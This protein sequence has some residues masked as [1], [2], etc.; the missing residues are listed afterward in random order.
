MNKSFYKN[1]GLSIK[2]WR[3]IRKMTQQ[4]LADKIGKGINFTGKIEVAFSKPRLDTL[5]DIADALD[6]TVSQLTDFK[7]LK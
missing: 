7:A 2:K 1:L 6:I 4:Q 5:I 3:S